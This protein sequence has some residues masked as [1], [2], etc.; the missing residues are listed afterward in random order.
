M[1]RPLITIAIP[2]YKTE[3][4]SAALRSAIS[5]TYDNIEIIVVD[6]CSP[7]NVKAIIDSFSDSRISYYRN[8]ANIG[9]DDPSQNWN[10]CLNLAKG[11][12]LCLLCDDDIYAP[13]YIE[14]M[15]LMA[16]KYP[17]A[18]IFRSG[19]KIIDKKEN[20]I[21]L[22]PLAPEHED[23]VE[24]I[25]HLHSGNNRQ[26]ISEWMLRVSALR[27]I[28]GYVNAPK[29]WGSDAM[30]IFALG[31]NS[32]IITSPER[33][34]SFRMSGINITGSEF[35]FIKEKVMGWSQ[36]CEMAIEI[37]RTSGADHKNFI[38]S[39]IWRDHKHWTR[40]LMKAGR[41]SEIIYLYKEKDSC[42]IKTKWFIKPLFYA[43]LRTVHLKK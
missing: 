38:I 25:W 13:T 22:F 4:L 6:D 10:Q 14:E 18:S 23:V 36:Q 31:R 8:D 20:V 43:L 41:L 37:V 11:D 12:Y 3:F 7:N 21:G 15:V 19:V 28:G 39:D 30:T 24:Y 33:L 26:T 27:S 42:H 9:A 17:K 5:Q 29:A 2:A 40:N 16:E 32:E 35:L 1:M 34:V